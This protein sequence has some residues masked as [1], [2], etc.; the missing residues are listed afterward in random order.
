MTV[1]GNRMKFQ[2]ARTNEWYGATLTL[3]EATNPKQ[4]LIQIQECGVP[5][6]VNKTTRAI[7]KLEKNT[8]TIAANEPGVEATPT[9]FMRRATNRSRVFVFFKR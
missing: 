1:S 7:Y 5:Q 4:A 2:G 8:L 9:E 3:N 6:Y